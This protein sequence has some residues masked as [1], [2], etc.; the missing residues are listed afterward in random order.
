MTILGIET[1]CDETAAAIVEGVTQQGP[2][3][4]LSA[5]V[6]SSGDLHTK[7]GGIVPEV[8]SREQVV[9]LLPVISIALVQT[10]MRSQ[11]SS[12]GGVVSASPTRFPGSIVEDIDAIAVTVGPGLVGSLLVGVETARALAFAWEKPLI[13]VNHLVAHLYANWA[14]VHLQ[15]QVSQPSFA[16]GRVGS[17]KNQTLS[18][19]HQES[20]VEIQY[21]K[22]PEFPAVG[23]VA[24]GGHTKNSSKFKVQSA[25]SQEMNPTVPT[26]PAIGLVVSGGHTDL[27][28]M[29]GHGNLRYLG[30][31]RDDAAGEAF[32]KI[33]RLLG[34]GFPGGPAIAAAAEKFEIRNSKFEIHLP[35]P[36]IDSEDYDFS[37]SGLKTA[38][39][40]QVAHSRQGEP[41]VQA[42]AFEAQEAIV[43]VLVT[44]VMRAVRE[45]RP[46]SLLLGGGVAANHRL[47]QMLKLQMTTLQSNVRLFI[48][49]PSLCMDNAVAIAATAFYRYSPVSWKTVSAHPGL[50]IV[51]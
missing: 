40:R 5:I 23:L 20:T 12:M 19:Q 33:A 27:V 4:V 46:R 43:E 17:S 11:P 30:G 45:F 47:R 26:F 18:A 41:A 3:R 24:S 21:S 22:A 42:V 38:V 44:K 32:D 10:L 50:S 1:S 25:K 6:A 49:P 36:M 2:V 34:L 15:S 13:P 28:L 29:K 9:S 8:A 31:T 48:P 7:T 14:D 16:A 51:G 35:R 39:M 37:F